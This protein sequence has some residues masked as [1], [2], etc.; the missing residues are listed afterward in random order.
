MAYDLE[1]QE[2]LDTLKA[3]W[4]Q[5]GN[6]V[7]WLLIICLTAFAGWTYWNNYQSGQALQA[8][9]L[10]E[11]L[12]KAAQAKDNAKVQRAAGDLIDKFGKTAYAPMAALSAAKSAFDANDLKAAKARLQWVVDQSGSDEYKALAGIRLAGIALDEKAYDEG[13]KLLAG[14]FPAEFAGEVADRK[15]DIY[16]AQNKM[17]EARTAYQTALE[18]TNEKNP[19]RQ[20]IQLKLEAIGGTAAAK[21]ASK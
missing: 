14:D 2:Q 1:E 20:L 9:Q 17:T 21:V 4:K 7:T 15:G 11:E 10:Y 16:T 5:Y 8:S 6:L 13:L 18:K 12:Q 3:W 19:G